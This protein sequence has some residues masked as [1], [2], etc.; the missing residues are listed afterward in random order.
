MTVCLH[1]HLVSVTTTAKEPG[2]NKKKKPTKFYF[3]HTLKHI[4][5]SIFIGRDLELFKA[6]S[7]RLSNKGSEISVSLYALAGSFITFFLLVFPANHTIVTPF[8]FQQ[9]LRLGICGG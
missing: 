1:T 6:I 8:P 7:Y 2:N 9:F 3:P 5:K 4:L